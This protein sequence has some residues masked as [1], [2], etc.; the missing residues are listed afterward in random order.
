[1][2]EVLR[3][4]AAHRSDGAAL[5]LRTPPPASWGEARGDRPP[6]P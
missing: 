3:R 2:D 6:A 1:V 5:A 4:E